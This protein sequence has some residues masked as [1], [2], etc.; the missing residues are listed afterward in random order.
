MR[1]V[2]ATDDTGH[3]DHIT[4][5]EAVNNGH[6]VDVNGVFTL[7]DG[8]VVVGVDG[9]NGSFHDLHASGLKHVVTGGVGIDFG[10][11]FHSQ[12]QGVA[13]GDDAEL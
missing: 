9:A 5:Y 2:V 4:F 13:S 10:N 3:S 7:C 12:R 8:S 1:S 11:G 6:L